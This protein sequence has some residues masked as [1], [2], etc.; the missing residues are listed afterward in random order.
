[1]TKSNNNESWFAPLFR[2]VGYGLLA[3]SI[4]DI[5]DIFVPSLFT[6][7]AWEFQTVRSLVERVPVPLL[8][9]VLVFSGEKSL[10][11]FKFLSWACLGAGLL[12][13]LLVPLGLSASFRLNQ[14][15]TAQVNPQV[16]QLQQLQGVLNKATTPAEIQSVLTRI[17]PQAGGVS[18]QDLPQVKSKL[19]SQIAER[20]KQLNAQTATERSNA[21]RVLIKNAVKSLLG[22]AVSGTIFI[23][24]WQRTNKA[25]KANRQRERTGTV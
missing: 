14:Q 19:L 13:I 7:P 21:Q 22:A 17:N 6:N 16:A 1:M 20:Q 25:L 24:L 8:G 4:F 3:L 9:A 12:F 5:I 23:M 10:R 15:L 2:L 18:A 11:V